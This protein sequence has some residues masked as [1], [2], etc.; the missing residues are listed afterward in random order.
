LGSA[1]RGQR[2]GGAQLL[3]HLRARQ[4]GALVAVATDHRVRPPQAV[5][6]RF[7]GRIHGGALWLDL[8][9]LEDEAGFVAQLANA[10][11]S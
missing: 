11:D 4:R 10:R 8:R 5:E 2:A 7:L 3:E 6:H 1:G 9:C